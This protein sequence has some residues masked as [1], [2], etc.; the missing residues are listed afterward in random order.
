MEHHVTRADGNAKRN[1]PLPRTGSEAARDFFT[2]W[3]ELN[4]LFNFILR[5]VAHIEVSGTKAHEYFVEYADTDEERERLVREWDARQ[6]PLKTLEAHRQ[7]FCEIFL[8]RHVE[9]FLSYLSSLLFAV[10]TTRPET[11][12]SGE[13]IDIDKVLRHDS[14]DTLVREI[15]RRKVQEL[16]YSSFADLSQYFK[17]RFGLAIT[18]AKDFDTLVTAIETRNIS[19]HNRCIINDRYIRITGVKPEVLGKKKS[20]GIDT[21]EIIV[22]LVAVLTRQLDSAATEKFGIRRVRFSATEAA[23]GQ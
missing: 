2:S 20:V 21:L 8:V 14:L 15:A 13:Q 23:T 19:V 17:Q 16:S 3:R 1:Y 18:P 5:M 22:P 9:N 12:R 6:G 11:L 7:V 10:F 4:R